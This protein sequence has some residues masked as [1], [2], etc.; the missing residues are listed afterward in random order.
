MAFGQA[1]A[2]TPTLLRVGGGD[3]FTDGTRFFTKT[4]RAIDA[5]LD[6]RGWRR[7]SGKRVKSGTSNVELDRLPFVYSHT[8]DSK[9][10]D[11]VT[12]ADDAFPPEGPW[13]SKGSFCGLLDRQLG[14]S[15]HLQFPFA[16]RFGC[17]CVSGTRHEAE[18][19]NRSITVLIRA[20]FPRDVIGNNATESNSPPVCKAQKNNQSGS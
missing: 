14:H 16:L 15:L 7:T 2:R 8:P 6:T 4:L 1:H 19:R 9:D 18:H 10:A 11:R 3:V 13:L 17:L 20:V 12:S 5:L